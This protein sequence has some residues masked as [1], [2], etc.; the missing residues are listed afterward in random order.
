MAT[1]AMRHAEL[2][3]TLSNFFY[4]L[5]AQL[6]SVDPVSL[7]QLPTPDTPAPIRRLEALEAGYTE[8]LVS[9]LE[10]L[11]YISKDP[12]DWHPE[13]MPSTEPIDFTKC[14]DADA[15]RMWREYDDGEDHE[16]DDGNEELIPGSVLK[17]TEIHLYGT[18]LLYDTQT[19]L[20]MAWEPNKNPDDIIGYAHVPARSP[21]E[22]LSPWI[23]DL[24]SFRY[25]QT[26]GANLWD[27]ESP[28]ETPQ[29]YS[30]L[31]KTH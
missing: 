31:K 11:P 26:P 20:L 7:V 28:V 9:L 17:L 8:E 25:I 27:G 13:M 16:D 29:H 19:R 15:F 3:Q 5:L 4:T 14:E 2:I 1:I 12:N 22:V 10:Q 30:P 18:T 24:G 6:G 21:S 23:E